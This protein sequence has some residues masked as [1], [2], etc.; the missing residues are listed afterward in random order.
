[1]FKKVDNKAFS[2]VELLAVVVILG[3]ISIMGISAT[4]MLA[5]KARESEMDSNKNVITMA[6][7]TY[8]QNNKSL[9]PKVIGETKNIRVIEFRNANYLTENIKNSKGESCMENSYVRV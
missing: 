1:M 2:L 3:I 7:Q 6:A 5:E 9:V 8:L 4:S